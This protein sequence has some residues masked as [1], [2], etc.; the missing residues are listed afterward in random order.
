[1]WGKPIPWKL[2]R[3]WALEP[4]GPSEPGVL[5]A[6][7]IPG[8]LFRSTDAGTTWTL[9]RSLWSHPR[10]KEWFGGGADLPGIHSICVDPRNSKHVTVGISCGGV[11]AT[12]DGGET[13]CCKAQGMFANFLPPEQKFEPN[14]QDPHCI[15]QC[16]GKPDSFWAQHHNGVFRSTNNC[17]SWEEVPNVPPSVFGFPVAVHPADPDIA[18]LVPAMNDERRIAMNGQ[19]V[20]SRTR[21]GGKSFTV[22]REGLPQEHA[23][24]LV[25]RHSLDIDDSGDRLAFGSTTGSLWVTENQGDSWQCVSQHLPPIYGVRFGK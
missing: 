19:V 14:L 17:A 2:E 9:I 23:Y 3:V 11:W 16:P 21:D 13:W 12:E 24:D 6:G 5:W 18:W 25:Y 8:G 7:T 10:R 1:M 4:A 20:V 15:V 22:L